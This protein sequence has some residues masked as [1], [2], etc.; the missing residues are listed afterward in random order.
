MQ[1][2]ACQGLKHATIYSRERNNDAFHGDQ[3]SKSTIVFTHLKQRYQ[4]RLIHYQLLVCKVHMWA[5]YEVVVIQST[6]QCPSNYQ[7]KGSCYNTQH[8]HVGCVEVTL[9]LSLR[10][11]FIYLYLF[12]FIFWGIYLHFLTCK[13]TYHTCIG[14]YD[15]KLD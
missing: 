15:N 4:D 2:L 1:H 5:W 9:Q 10:Y 13:S 6:R 3:I 8:V 11:L 12:T 7:E 14:L